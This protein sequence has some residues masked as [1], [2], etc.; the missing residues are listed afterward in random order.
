MKNA[1]DLMTRAIA[2][3][4]QSQRVS[5]SSDDWAGVVLRFEGWRVIISRNACDYRCQEWVSTHGRWGPARGASSP[6][7]WA[8]IFSASHPQF[9]GRLLALPR[10]ARDAAASLAFA[11]G[12]ELPSAYRV[13]YWSAPDYAGVI[14]TDENLRSV[15]DRSGR[16]YAI[17]WRLPVPPAGE[18]V[19]WITQAKGSFWPDLVNLMSGKTHSV[20]DLG[21]PVGLDALASRLCDLFDDCPLEA[22]GGPLSAVSAPFW[23]SSSPAPAL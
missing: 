15:V 8:E 14:C 10:D 9:A 18:P 21:E 20:D 13:R 5:S 11:Q 23:L 4:W 6:S 19:S 22:Q 3:F 16:V 1:P 2:A 12:I 17:Q 7:V